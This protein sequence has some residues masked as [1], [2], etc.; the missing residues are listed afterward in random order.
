MDSS[1][2]SEMES[3]QMEL[4]IC[5]LKVKDGFPLEAEKAVDGL[6]W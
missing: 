4:Q 2:K 3:T 1:L 5:M 6:E